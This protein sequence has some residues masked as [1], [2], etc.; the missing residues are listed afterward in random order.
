[1]TIIIMTILITTINITTKLGT[2]EVAK[3]K[4]DP[5]KTKMMLA[6]MTPQKRPI[7]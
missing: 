5:T 1:M 7:I 6:K 4:L 2:T 3:W